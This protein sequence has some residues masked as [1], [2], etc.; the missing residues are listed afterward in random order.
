VARIWLVVAAFVAI[1]LSRS[2]A[3]GIPVRDTAGATS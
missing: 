1:T 2:M 3:I